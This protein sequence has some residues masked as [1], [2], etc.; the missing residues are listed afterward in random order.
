R[1]G[2]PEVLHPLV[3]VLV[4][5]LAGHAEEG[6]AELVDVLVDLGEDQLGDGPFG[7]GVAGPSVLGGRDVGEAQHHGSDPV[8]HQFVAHGGGL[9]DVRLLVPDAHRFG[10]GARAAVRHAAATPADG[11]ALVGQG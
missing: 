9:V 1:A 5:D 3:D 8:L 2:E 11:G 4:V 6:D 7:A 10:D